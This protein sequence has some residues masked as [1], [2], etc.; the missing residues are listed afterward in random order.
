MP[1]EDTL[2]YDFLM[3]KYVSKAQESDEDIIG[4]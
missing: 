1:L 3:V 2:S 4:N